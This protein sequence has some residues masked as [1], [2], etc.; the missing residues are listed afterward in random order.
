MPPA[1]L[2]PLIKTALAEDVGTG[3]ITSR[4]LIP[5]GLQTSVA[6][7]A[8]Q[9]MV[10]A[11]IDVPAM[12]YDELDKNITV[13]TRAKDGDRLEK[14]AVIAT[15]SGNARA[16]LTGERTALNLMQRMSGVAT[17]TRQ[18]VDA[19]AGTKAKILD[20]RKTMPGM[21]QTDK[22]AVRMGGGMNHRMGLWDA[23]LVKDNHIA[24]AGNLAE[25]V[26]YG[27]AGKVPVYVECDTLAQL[28]ET[29]AAKPNRIMLDN[30]SLEMLREA[31]AMTAGKVLLEA[32]GGVNLSNV[33]AVAET[34][35]DY[36][37]VGAIT[38]S[39]PAVDI[40]LDVL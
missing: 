29:L 9:E 19:I 22:Y 25:A 7:V 40:G 17:L 8:R 1:F 5:E 6:F 35:V 28:A 34:G 37:S 10:L 38:H 31:V 2:L 32:T 14:S 4:L 16:I 30:M 12:V 20:T 39:A 27:R 21:R 33:R 24:L 3:D 23:V 18:Y 36:I 11:G 15:L 26:K 13:N